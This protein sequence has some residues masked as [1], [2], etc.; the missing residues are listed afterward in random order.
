MTKPPPDQGWRMARSAAHELNERSQINIPTRY[1][2][3]HTPTAAAPGERRC[4]G[5]GAGAFRDNA[6]PLDQESNGAL[7]L[8]ELGDQSAVEQRSDK[9]PHFRKHA[10]TADAVDKAWDAIDDDRL[11]RGERGGE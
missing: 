2:T 3:Y 4:N 7:H 8:V 6:P 10:T 11:P 1:N 9:W 5:H